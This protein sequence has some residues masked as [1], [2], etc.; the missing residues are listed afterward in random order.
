MKEKKE[1]KKETNKNN[2]KENRKGIRN[3]A[4]KITIILCFLYYAI[5]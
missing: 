4:M 3:F 1:E 2:N 5:A